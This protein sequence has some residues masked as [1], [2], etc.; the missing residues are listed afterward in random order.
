MKVGRHEDAERE[1]KIIE[2]LESK[3]GEK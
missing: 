1:L 2:K 3:A